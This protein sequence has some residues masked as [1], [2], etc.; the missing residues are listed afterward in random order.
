[1]IEK[2]DK[3]T[4]ITIVMLRVKIRLS[5]LNMTAKI[6]RFEESIT[7]KSLMEKIASKLGVVDFK[8]RKWELYLDGDAEVESASDINDGDDLVLKYLGID[9]E[10][11]KEEAVIIKT[12]CKDLKPV[13]I[14]LVSPENKKGMNKKV[15]DIQNLIETSV[16]HNVKPEIIHLVNCDVDYIEDVTEKVLRDREKQR[17]KEIINCNGDQSSESEEESKESSTSSSLLSDSYDSSS[18]SEEEAEDDSSY[19][20]FSSLCDEDELY[21]SVMTSNRKR[22]RHPR[23]PLEPP[24]QCLMDEKDVPLAP[25]KQVD[26]DG[27]GKKQS[28][29]M[30]GFSTLANNFGEAADRKIKDRIIKLLNTGFHETSNEYEAQNA[31]KM[32]QRLMRKHNLF[33][34]LMLQER[35]TVT[36]GGQDREETL[37]GGMANVR[38]INR[39]TDRKAQMAQWIVKLCHPI[40]QNFAV[41]CFCKRR[42]SAVVFYG[43]YT[44]TQL[45]AYAFRVATERISQMAVEYQPLKKR[46]RCSTKS[47]R[48]SYAL[49]IVDGISKEVDASLSREEER[50]RRKLERARQATS[51]GDVYEES[52]D[53]EEEN[54]QGMYDDDI[55]NNNDDEMAIGY[56]FPERAESIKNDLSTITCTAAAAMPENNKDKLHGCLSGRK[57]EQKVK[58]IEQEEKAALVLVD[59]RKKVAEKVLKD[60]QIKLTKGRKSASIQFDRYSYDKG[61]EDST[62]IDL[63]QRAIRDKVRVKKEN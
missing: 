23:P 59:H 6:L 21:E 36:S 1:L 15:N 3:A 16:R 34:V 25:G 41:E 2:L 46:G 27:D 47:S 31:M 38:I 62:E 63:N 37:K 17:K 7:F 39:K 42:K 9:S 29:Y 26:K 33:Q 60:N 30:E 4:T 18:E 40:K 28:S 55:A 12:E 11:K 45:A 44:N 58:N 48:L 49:G 19:S 14:P 20:D 22:K 61:V 10:V 43:L 50:R 54:E 8:A 13:A 24:L 53:E 5:C 35:D 32:A 57:L 56:S 51:K 52:A